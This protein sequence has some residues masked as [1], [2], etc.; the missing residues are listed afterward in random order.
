VVETEP[1]AGFLFERDELQ[2]VPLPP[3]AAGLI[4]LPSGCTAAQ[5]TVA[6]TWNSQGA[7]LQALSDTVGLEPAA[8]V[9]VLCVES[10]GKGFADDGRMVIRFEN[11]VFWD[12]WGKVH[13]D[14]F[15]AHFRFNP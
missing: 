10:G 2:G 14:V 13:A 9:A 5:K 6:Q 8:A 12:K 7:L 3:A 4:K 11:H 15:N 1:A